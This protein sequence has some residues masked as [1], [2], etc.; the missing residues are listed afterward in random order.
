[1]ARKTS[2]RGH[3]GGPPKSSD[4]YLG[5]RNV[6]EAASFYVVGMTL[7]FAALG[8]A[9]GGWFDFSVGLGAGAGAFAGFVLSNLVL[10]FYGGR[11]TR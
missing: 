2:S 1:M 11:Q 6:R 3:V 9:A 7:L 10:T 8:A 4:P 5:D